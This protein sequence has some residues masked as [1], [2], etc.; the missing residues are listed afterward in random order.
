MAQIDKVV[1]ML[2]VSVFYILDRE[3]HEA[4]REIRKIRYFFVFDGPI[5]ERHPSRVVQDSCESRA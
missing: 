4:Q 1:R 5:V 2:M 3:T